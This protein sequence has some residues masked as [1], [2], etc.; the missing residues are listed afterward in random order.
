MDHLGARLRSEASGVPARYRPLFDYLKSRFADSL[1]LTFGQIEDLL[2]TPL[3][4]EARRS[5]AWWLPPA[6]NGPAPSA[7]SGAWR[8][9]NRRATPNLQAGTVRFDRTLV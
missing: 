3:P 5:E 6:E 8:V 9:A 7:A 2:G 1:V 4:E